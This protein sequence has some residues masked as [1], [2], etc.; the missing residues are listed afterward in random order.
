[1]RMASFGII[2]HQMRNW[3]WNFTKQSNWD[4]N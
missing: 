3:E 4:P 1:V 2:G